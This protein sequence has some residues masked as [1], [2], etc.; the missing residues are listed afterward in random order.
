ML[1]NAQKELALRYLPHILKD[2]N[3]P[4]P[5]RYIGVSVFE[6]PGISPTFARLR[7][8]PASFDAK[9]IIE[10][11]VYMDYDIQHL[12]ELE[13]FWIAVGEDGSVKDCLC[14]YHGLCIHATGIPEMYHTEDG[15][16]VLYMQPGKHAFMPDPKLFGLHV[17]K[18]ACC[19]EL[20]GGGLLIPQMLHDKLTTTPERD[21]RIR[22]YIRRH[23]SFRPSWEFEPVAALNPEQL[24]S[25][26]ELLERIP[27][28]VE[29]QLK[30][31]EATSNE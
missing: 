30:I 31:I 1:S 29:E 6:A 22:D 12:Y 10:Y 15:K 5:I 17:I 16:P 2:K 19:F 7:L 9:L 26:E 8:D 27:C 14:S 3:E 11:A 13:H 24:L 23:F 25:A 21:S 20:A 28:L 4:F 18:D